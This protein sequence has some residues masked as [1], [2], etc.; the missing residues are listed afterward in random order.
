MNKFAVVASLALLLPGIAGAV[1]PVSVE[2]APGA[3]AVDPASEQLTCTSA[4]GLGGR[5]QSVCLT[6]GQRAAQAANAEVAAL[7]AK[8]TAAPAHPCLI[9][10]P[11]ADHR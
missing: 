10:R 8:A 6:A 5:S 11:R 2:R 3:P 9:E 1:Q 7:R 4:P